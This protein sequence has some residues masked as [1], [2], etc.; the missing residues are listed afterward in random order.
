[1]PFKFIHPQQHLFKLILLL[2]IPCCLLLTNWHTPKGVKSIFSFSTQQGYHFSVYQVNDTTACV[3]WTTLKAEVKIC[4]SPPFE[5]ENITYAYYMRPGGIDNEG[6]D[7]NHLRFTS[8]GY[9]YDV[10]E[11]YAAAD[12]SK[13]IGIKI[14]NMVNQDVKLY[15]ALPHSITGSLIHLRNQ[16]IFKEVPPDF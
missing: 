14:T 12:S 3:Q 6:L 4:E 5:K 9:A 11:N 13:E 2:A 8:G 15:H 10:F 16:E 1:M 7:L